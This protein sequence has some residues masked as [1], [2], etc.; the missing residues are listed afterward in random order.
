MPHVRIERLSDAQVEEFL[1]LYHAERGPALWQQLRGT[2][3]LDLFRSPFYLRMLLAQD[4]ADGATLLSGRAAL[5]TGLVRQRSYANS[6]LI[7][8]YCDPAPC[9]T[10]ATTNNWCAAA[11]ATPTICPRAAPC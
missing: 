7:R 8:R 1:S 6:K 11:G 9:S 10:G 2:P 5:F 3:Q 4:N